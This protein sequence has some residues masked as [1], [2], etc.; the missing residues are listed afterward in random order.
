MVGGSADLAPSTLTLID[1]GG[2]VEAGELRRPQPALRHPRAR[3]GRD[4]Q[5]P[6]A[7]RLPRLRR[8]VPDLQ[9]LHEGRRSGSR[10]SCTSRRRSCSRT[11][12]SAWGRTARRTSRSSSS[13]RC[14]RRRTSTSSGPPGFNETALAW[15]HALRQTD[16]PTV[17][18]LC[19]QGL[20]GLGPGRDPRRRDRARRLRAARQRRRR[21]AADPDG[22]RVRGPHRERRRQAARGRRHP[23]TA[24]VDAVPRPLRRAGPGLPRPASCRRPSARGWRSRRRA[25]SAGTAGSATSATSSRWRASAPPRPRRSSTSTSGSPARRS[26]SAPG[27]CWPGHERHGGQRA[28]RGADRG[29]HERLARPDPPRDDRERRA[30]ADGRGGL[31]AR[32]HVEPGDLRE[33]DPRLAGL[34]RGHRRRR[35]RRALRA[36]GLPPAR[37]PR[38]PARGRHAPRRCTT[39]RTATTATCRSRSRRGS[40]T[41]PRG[42]SSRRASTGASS[43]GPT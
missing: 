39:R 34:R 4:R 33:G 17:L 30:G 38:R 29:G 43:T 9:R 42:R 24:R 11:T 18:A 14:A 10:R 23:G 31:A 20:P 12:R 2:S 28:A 35:A 32:R 5:R 26:P 8:R 37:G 19:R 15:R 22:D 6:R 40:R 41:T 16:R 27:R 1:G 13:S 36:R 25:R 7:E 3:D 21:P